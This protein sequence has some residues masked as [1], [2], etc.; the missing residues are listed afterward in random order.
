MKIRKAFV[1]DPDPVMP[2]YFI[3][4]VGDMMRTY[5]SPAG[6]EESKLSLTGIT[7]PY[8]NARKKGYFEEMNEELTTDHLN[9]HVCYGECREGKTW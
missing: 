8:D 5:L 9:N 4:D 3:S 7:E 6:E 2:G 1:I